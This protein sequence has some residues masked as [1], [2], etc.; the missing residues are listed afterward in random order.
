M[1][2]PNRIYDRRGSFS[3]AKTRAG[4]EYVTIGL[5]DPQYAEPARFNWDPATWVSLC[6][7]LEEIAPQLRAWLDAN[8]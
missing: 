1:D 7:S 5:K 4:W 6:T 3:V 8:P 2:S